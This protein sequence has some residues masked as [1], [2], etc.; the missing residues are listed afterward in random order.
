MRESQKE[1]ENAVIVVGKS[2]GLEQSTE[3]LLKSAGMY[4]TVRELI[5]LMFVKN[6]QQYFEKD[7]AV[8]EAITLIRAY[9]IEMHTNGEVNFDV[10]YVY[11]K[12]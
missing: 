11:E 4:S 5:Y 6:K 1:L 7:D 9:C 12:K 3:A 10:P 2:L 8:F